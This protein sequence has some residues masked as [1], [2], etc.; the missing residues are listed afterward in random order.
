MIVQIYLWVVMV[1]MAVV[2][3]GGVAMISSDKENKMDSAAWFVFVTSGALF[4]ASTLLLWFIPE[5]AH[6]G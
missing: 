4:I 2:F 1:Y 6:V 5:V 3:Y